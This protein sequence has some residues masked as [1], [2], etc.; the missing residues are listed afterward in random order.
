[1]SIKDAI[2]A[3]IKEDIYCGL[4]WDTEMNT[5]RGIFTIRDFLNL[6]KVIYDKVS[7]H[8][9]KI[10]KWSNIKNLISHILQRNKLE[11]EDLDAIIEDDPDNFSQNS[12]NS[13]EGM[14]V[15][16]ECDNLGFN[17]TH[18]YKIMEETTKSNSPSKNNSSSP[19]KLGS[20][21]NSLKNYKEFFKIFEYININDYFSEY[22]SV[23]K[24]FF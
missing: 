16:D 8:L 6:I 18:N 21:E 14:I 22:H 7:D 1:L 13:G 15:D 19:N 2:E 10:G 24:L 23:S 12:N 9:E 5:F 4:I 17:K 3:M 20:I 11:L